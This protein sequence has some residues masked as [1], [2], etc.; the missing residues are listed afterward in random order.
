M[1]ITK[2]ERQERYGTDDGPAI[3]AFHSELGTMK[4]DKKLAMTAKNKVGIYRPRAAIMFPRDKPGVIIV[5]AEQAEFRKAKELYILHE[6]QNQDAGLLFDRMVEIQQLMHIKQT[7]S[8]LTPQEA[9]FVN[10]KN[11]ELRLEKKK[12]LL[13]GL[14]P[15]ADD[16]GNI[17]YHLNVLKDLSRPGKERLFYRKES[18]LPQE[19]AQIPDQTHDAIDTEHPF[20][21][22]VAYVVSALTLYETLEPDMIYPSK[23]EYD[24]L[25]FDRPDPPGVLLK[26]DIW[27]D[28]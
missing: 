16:N 8:R 9:Q 23:R 19:V 28:M 27:A 25:D 10:W 15:L 26:Y 5:A 11:S 2:I 22:A 1:E 20:L 13:I 14:P 3:F 17:G 4:T 21:A 12:D 6:H 18:N 7:F 24:P